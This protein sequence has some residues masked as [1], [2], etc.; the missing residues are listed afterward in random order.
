MK[1]HE[2][3]QY[4]RVDSYTKASMLDSPDLGKQL[5]HLAI[6]RQDSVIK[7]V[8]TVH[9]ALY[10]EWSILI[11][12]DQLRRA[13][14]GHHIREPPAYANFIGY[15]SSQNKAKAVEYWKNRLAGVTP[16][17]IYPKLPSRHHLVRPSA[18]YNR[19]LKYTGAHRGNL[20]AKVY[21]SWTLIVAKLMGS[22]DVLFAS[23]LTG[24]NIPVKGVEQMVG[25]MITPVPIRV[26]L[27]TIKQRVDDFLTMIQNEITEMAPFQHVGTRDI[28][29]IDQDTQ[30]AS[31][32]Q[33]LIVMTPAKEN[34]DQTAEHLTTSNSELENFKGDSFHTFALV[35]FLFPKNRVLI[36]K[37]CLTLTC[38]TNAKS[39]ALV[40]DWKKL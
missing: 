5:S 17:S 26:R 16:A 22:D 8:W 40:V 4:D 2:W 19:T 7:I 6:I 14:K 34:E 38:S 21:A 11:L 27:G 31:K 35:L 25:P 3:K 29:S 30:A 24:R 37:S 33:T 39:N 9:H 15:L 32:F 20:Q 12:E 1:G 18:V 36:S 10:D 23:T 28:Q 13:Y